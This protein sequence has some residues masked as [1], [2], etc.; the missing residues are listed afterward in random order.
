MEFFDH[1]EHTIDDKGRLVLPSA[2]RAA[3]VDGGYLTDMGHYAGLFTPD[4]W[5]SYRRRMEQTKLFTRS[6]LQVMFS[7]VSPFTPDSQHRITVNTR[8]R[9]KVG[10]GRAVTITGAGSHAAIHP[11]ARWLEREAQVTVPDAEGR[12][13]AD[14]IERMD[15]L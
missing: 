13:L 1:F 7:Y 3:F 15:F 6:E 12:S 10:L 14:R 8:L 2:Y 9:D 5:T 11:R 4:G